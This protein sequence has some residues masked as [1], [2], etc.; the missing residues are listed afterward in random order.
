M[1]LSV[2]LILTV[3]SS[4]GLAPVNASVKAGANC[5]KVNSKTK[6]GGDNYVC[7]KNPIVKKAKLTW[8]W[9]GCLEANNLYVDSSSRLK[10]VVE[11]ANQAISEIDTSIAA[12]KAS[13]PSDEAE[14]K[15]FDQKAADAKLKQADAV[16]KAKLAADK[17]VAAG[18]S[19][20]AGL[21]YSKAAA[22][23]NAAARSYQSAIANFERS[24]STLRAKKDQVGTLE[25]RKASVQRTVE[26]AT[27]E[28]KAT[29]DTRKNACKP[30]L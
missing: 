18:A 22:Q 9:V 26:S 5:T 27:S 30:G 28:V 21:S 12:V 19:T 10:L 7:T 6:I 23:W 8:V 17:A 13:A 16:A 14:A 20:A 29:F 25:A 4:I 15:I 1:G 11:K 2:L 3:N 24:A